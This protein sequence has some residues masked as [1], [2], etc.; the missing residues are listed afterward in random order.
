MLLHVSC[1]LPSWDSEGYLVKALRGA[2]EAM[3]SA[4]AFLFCTW[5]HCT[6]PAQRNHITC[7]FWS[8][9]FS[10]VKQIIACYKIIVSKLKYLVQRGGSM[11]ILHCIF[12]PASCFSLSFLPFFPFLFFFL[13]SLPCPEHKEQKGANLPPFSTPDYSFHSLLFAHLLS[14]FSEP[15]LPTFGF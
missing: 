2:E 8:S 9:I 11:N 1:Q 14:S 12:F 4:F 10:S 5:L 3:S 7:F 6:Q 13:Y 15:A